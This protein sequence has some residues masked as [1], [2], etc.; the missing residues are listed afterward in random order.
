MIK[1][2]L[3][4][5]FVRKNGRVW[6]EYERYVREH[7]EEHRLHRF[8]HLKV[9]IKLNWFYRVKQGNTPYLYWDVPLNVMEKKQPVTQN[10]RIYPESMAYKREGIDNF[11]KKLLE[12]DVICFDCFDTLLFRTVSNPADL[13]YLLE[14][15]YKIPGFKD[16]R[17]QALKVAREKNSEVSIE[18]IYQIIS[19]YCP[20]SVTAKDEIDMEYKVTYANEYM[21]EVVKKLKSF[22]KEIVC[23][24]D[25]YL[26]N[27]EVNDLLVAAGYPMMKVFTSSSEGVAKKTGEL[28]KRI[29]KKIGEN[30]KYIL[31]GDNYESDFVQSRNVEM[32]SYWYKNCQDIGKNY[33]SVA[34][35]SVA[36]SAYSAVVNNY[37]HCGTQKIVDPYYEHGFAYGGII[38][39]GFC[40]FIEELRERDNYDKFVF[41]A[42]DM[43]IFYEVY[44][45][46]F[47]HVKCEYALFS[48]FS[49]QQLIFEFLT[50]EYLNYTIFTRI[51]KNTIAEA[52]NIYDL[53]EFDEELQQKGI[54]KNEKLT[55][56]NYEYVKEII[57]ENKKKI[58]DLFKPVV[59]TAK[60]Y[61]KKI[62]GDSKNIC[63]LDLGWKGT[64]V[65]YLSRLFR[66]WGWDVKVHGAIVSMSGNPYAQSLCDNKI[67]DVYMKRS[68]LDF[69]TGVPAKSNFETFRGHMFETTFTSQDE[70]LLEF[71]EKENENI[72]A[73][74]NP[75]ISL[76]QQIHEGIIDFCDEF[77]NRTHGI[78]EYCSITGYSANVPINKALKTKSYTI[79]IWGY[80]LDEASS[81]PGF[82][83]EPNYKTFFQMM[84]VCK[85]ANDEDL[86]ANLG[87][88]EESKILYICSTYSQLLI[89]IITVITEKKDD[90]DIILYDD[91]PN[92]SLLRTRLRRLNL[93]NN[94]LIFTK[95]GLPQRFHNS[96][97]NEMK[98]MQLH[99]AHLMA[100]ESRMPVNILKYKE[101]Y[102]F[103][104]GHHL[105]LYLQEKHIKYHLIEDGMNHFQHIMAT[106]SAKEIPVVNAKSIKNYLKGC[107]YLCCGQ[108]PDCLSIEV[109]ENKNLAITHENIIEKPRKEMFNLLSEN[110]KDSIFEVFLEDF[111][112]VKG[113]KNDLAI[114]FTSVLAND[115]WV[116]N[117]K[118]QIRI[119]RDIVNK[120]K[121]EG[122]YVILKPHPRD[123]VLY[124]KEFTDCYIMDKNF[125]SELLDF[126]TGLHFK[127]G[128]VIASSAMEL[129]NC[130]EKKEKL[131]FKFFENYR[132]VVAPWVLESLSHSETYNW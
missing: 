18:D 64:A 54:N 11:V 7:M 9:L 122:Y 25:M 81:E 92:C 36:G 66:E 89:S 59:E 111:D 79:P 38:V 88:I 108:N 75:N 10:N 55:K 35:K 27:S 49:S 47:D 16:L 73:R 60:A 115:G 3:Y 31:V 119:Y 105:G 53:P 43:K 2:K 80:V 37:L 86:I 24:S 56:D 65:L 13:F 84:K 26:S 68:E 118:T 63:I 28:Q 4:N 52:L 61:Y 72:F 14:L 69:I 90:V 95:E 78:S 57:Y 107:N 29:V 124:S 129:I 20:N 126:K 91:L 33:R 102:I 96:E 131:G 34:D 21:L 85:L 39:Y 117:E 8:R 125:P 23:I 6:Y 93:F 101:V 110:E 132:G 46:F 71:G 104:D 127:K 121:L 106:P 45:K 48:R 130:I 51:G 32:D 87:V 22:D 15:K 114:V 99:Y 97:H 109:N 82:S 58:I 5:Y 98:L 62:V 50:E 77:S 103:Y 94:I 100:V 112:F 30:K 41:L 19:K 1:D 67:L 17:M 113:I 76:I 123:K 83:K 40:K 116:D 44:K 128:V 70:S 74:K 120:L 42:R 12:Y